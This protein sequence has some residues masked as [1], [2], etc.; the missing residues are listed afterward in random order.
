MTFT[1]VEAALNATGIPWKRGQRSTGHW[2]IDCPSNLRPWGMDE[3]VALRDAVIGAG[4]HTTSRMLDTH[5][6]EYTAHPQRQFRVYR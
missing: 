6:N 5:R 1:D 3:V 2:I 4:F